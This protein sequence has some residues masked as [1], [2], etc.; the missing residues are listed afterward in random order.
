MTTPPSLPVSVK[1]ANTNMYELFLDELQ[2]PVTFVDVIPPTNQDSFN[3]DK[4]LEDYIFE[5]AETFDHYQPPRDRSILESA[6]DVSPRS[7][8]TFSIYRFVFEKK[9]DLYILYISRL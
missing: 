7:Y 9:T 5:M 6:A 4:I 1:I 3:T 2:T 8:G